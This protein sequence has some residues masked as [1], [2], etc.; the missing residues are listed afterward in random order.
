MQ[1]RIFQFKMVFYR[2]DGFRGNVVPIE[3]IINNAG[4]MPTS[5]FNMLEI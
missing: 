5:D 3:M 2:N 4:K 1:M